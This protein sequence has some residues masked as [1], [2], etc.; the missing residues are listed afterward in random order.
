MPPLF[1]IDES[2]NKTISSNQALVGYSE[3]QPGNIREPIISQALEKRFT[4]L[5]LEFTFS[6][7]E[8]WFDEVPHRD[9]VRVHDD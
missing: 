2:M 5:T 6:F 1:V 3:L 8:C 7:T 9:S 4:D